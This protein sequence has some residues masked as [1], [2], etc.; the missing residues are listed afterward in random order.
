MKNKGYTLVELILSI[1]VF[2]VVMVSIISIMSSV[3]SNYKNSTFEVQVQEEAQLVGNQL[4]DLLVDAQGFDVSNASAGKYRFTLSS[5]DNIDIV[6]DSS[7]N[8]LYYLTGSDEEDKHLL[9]DSVSSFDISGLQANGKDNSCVVNLSYNDFNY[10]YDLNKSIYF[11]NQIE[12]SGLYD[13]SN[14]ITPGTTTSDDSDE[15]KDTICINR[16]DKFNLSSNYGWLK[17]DGGVEYKYKLSDDADDWY[18]LNQPT[19]PFSVDGID[20]ACYVSVNDTVR[21]DWTKSIAKDDNIYVSKLKVNTDGTETEVEKIRLY[22][23][24]VK[25]HSEDGYFYVPKSINSSHNNSYSTLVFVDGIDVYDSQS[26]L[27]YSFTTSDSN[28]T[29]S[30][31][32]STDKEE[33]NVL[34]LKPSK[35]MN[36]LSDGQ[37]LTVSITIKNN[38]TSTIK[39]TESVSYTV[40]AR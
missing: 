11:R 22:T 15:F 27:T 16:Y 10:T 23:K 8:N 28:K 12:N 9:S 14:M 31:M 21:D 39:K 29:V 18:V 38:T 1:A 19:D 2:S 26:Y 13:I 4:S 35:D 36:P 3:A 33:N 25:I 34:I 32:D 20:K 7:E 5:G 17:K 6:F 24:A 37:T 40:I 30:A